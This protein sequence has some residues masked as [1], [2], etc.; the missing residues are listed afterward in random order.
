MCASLIRH[1]S[2]PGAYQPGHA[3]VEHPVAW[4][5]TAFGVMWQA[6]R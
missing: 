1:G 4:D 3:A 6:S 2:H 5:R